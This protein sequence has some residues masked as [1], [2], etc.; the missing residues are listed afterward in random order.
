MASDV[1]THILLPATVPTLFVIMI[2][3]VSLAAWVAAHLWI[4]RRERP[5]ERWAAFVALALLGSLS[6]WFVFNVLA[7][8]FTLETPWRLWVCALVSGVGAEAVIALYEHEGRTLRRATRTLVSV[9]RVMLLLLI[10]AMLIEPVIV[11]EIPHEE[12]RF[13]AVLA[14]VSASMDVADTQASASEKL[15]LAEALLPAPEGAERPFRAESWLDE[16]TAARESIAPQVA[17]LRL[18][19]DGTATAAQFDGR[20]ETLTD[21]LN[22]ASASVSDLAARLSEF[23]GGGN[24]PEDN[25]AALRAVGTELQQKVAVP[26]QNAADLV[27]A[28]DAA[29][30]VEQ[31]SGV[32]ALLEPAEAGLA[33][34]IEALPPLCA[35]ADEATLASLPDPSREAVEQLAA[36]T[37][38]AVAHALLAGREDA[39]G[40]I[41]VLDKKYSVRLYEFG[42][43]AAEAGL[44][45]LLPGRK[46]TDPAAIRMRGSTDLA[47]ALERVR[48]DV[49]SGK[50]AGVLVLSDGRHNAAAS[51]DLMARRLGTESVVACSVLVG[52]TIAPPDAAVAAVKAPRVVQIENRVVV[53]ADLRFNGMADQTA[54]VTLVRDDKVLD[55]KEIPISGPVSPTT[56][57]L[58]HTPVEAG[59]QAYEVR[60]ARIGDERIVTNNVLTAY[61]DVTD[62]PTKLLMIDS[63]PRWEFRYLRRLFE[64]RDKSVRLQHVLMRPD[65]IEEIAPPQPEHARAERKIGEA[66]MLPE[67]E[68]DWLAFDV[69]ILGDVSPADLGPGGMEAI[70]K[71]VDRRGGGLIVIAGPQ[72]MPHAFAGTPL[73][74]LMPCA[75]EAAEYAV[76]NAPEGVFRIALTS[77]GKRHTLMALDSD[78]EVNEAIWEDLPD[79]AWRHPVR[80]AKPGSTVL[81]FAMPFETPEFFRPADSGVLE[82]QERARQREEFERR[83]PL[84][85]IQRH[86]PGRVAALMF[87]RTW[88]LRYRTGDPDHH[89]FWGQ[90]LRW[91]GPIK[92][93]AGS[94]LAR[95]GTDRRVYTPGEPV[96]VNARLLDKEGPGIVAAPDAPVAVWAVVTRGQEQVLRKRLDHVGNSS[97]L[98]EGEL[99]T[100]PPGGRYRIA[101]EVE[102]PKAADVVAAAGQASLD[103]VVGAEA[104][105]EMIDLAADP[106]A[107]D[108]LA[109]LSQ[110]GRAVERPDKAAALLDRFGPGTH[111]RVELRKTAVWH[112]WPLFVL[113]VC[114]VAAEW[115]LRK[116]EGLT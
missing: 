115:I 95:L 35:A 116:R 3:A 38:R 72:F 89:R 32:L 96:L 29:G 66:D 108:E 36:R 19:R 18:V 44:D 9:L 10:A 75:F 6:V 8:F 11:D 22:E 65:L 82:A 46:E 57:E 34:A 94:D 20:R 31:A 104:S 51:I 41:S 24:L 85:V 79:I 87:D 54:K 101:L 49:A 2:A 27:S 37:R 100:L 58:A 69:I 50:L 64:E 112:S 33:R 28:S 110:S 26:L 84:I 53:E 111:T 4:R 14:D 80:E 7:R 78:G 60:I 70:S 98:Y 102:A 45:R 25:A 103:V 77:A 23:T 92:L 67:T 5:A 105:T 81:A 83:N 106:A 93:P 114:V 73:E 13:V 47:A 90:M 88:R 40:L 91:A 97:G 99:G 109:R 71:F 43:Q 55:Q 12:E 48:S 56:V 16:A 61:V 52:S 68:K 113:M 39:P 1:Q 63:R 21:G 42:S 62:D 76:L 74:D 30:L 17:W 59:V 107:L 15:A 86:P